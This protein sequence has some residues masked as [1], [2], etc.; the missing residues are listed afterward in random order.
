MLVI[1]IFTGCSFS[2]PDQGPDLESSTSGKASD[3]I[4]L[5]TTS[6][7]DEA[8]TYL[9]SDITNGTA[10]ASREEALL[11]AW[12]AREYV[13]ASLEDPYLISGYWEEDNYT[14]KGV[15]KITRLFS[16]EAK[17]QFQE[18]LTLLR[19]T[20]SSEDGQSAILYLSQIIY[21]P[22]AN[23]ELALDSSCY[24]TWSMGSCRLSE[25]VISN[26]EVYDGENETITIKL[27][28]EATPLFNDYSGVVFEPRLY[29]YE[30]N[31]KKTTLPESIDTS[32][33]IFT[34]TKI[35]GTLVINPTEK[36]F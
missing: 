19:D 21:M 3:I 27:N 26:I 8:F 31:L 1:T 22:T 23:D 15:E 11:A 32:T 12:T 29:S 25:V 5:G 14:P 33:P 20:P 28:A 10:K 4:G 34:I 6:Q 13:Y 7:Y 24:D 9:A 35:N 36:L 30:F 17:E 2:E 16:G 18:T